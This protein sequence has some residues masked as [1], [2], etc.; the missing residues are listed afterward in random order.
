LKRFSDSYVEV[1]LPLRQG[2]KHQ[3]ILIPHLRNFVEVPLPLRQG[4]KHANKKIK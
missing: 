4:L 1:P 2:L 3:G